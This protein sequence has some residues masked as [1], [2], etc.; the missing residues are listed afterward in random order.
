MRIRYGWALVATALCAGAVGAFA[1]P[2]LGSAPYIVY[3]F[4]P[5]GSYKG[6]GTV[7]APGAD[8]SRW[9]CRVGS[10]SCDLCGVCHTP[11]QTKDPTY[12]AKYDSDRHKKIHFPTMT[13][14][15]A[16]GQKL[17]WGTDASLVLRKTGIAVS[18]NT[19]GKDIAIMPANATILFN[20]LKQAQLIALPPATD[21]TLVP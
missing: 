13:A 3:V 1:S 11:T 8:G 17:A 12:V 10:D 4:N 9:A 16:P 21:L 20:R 2:A 18:L 6:R 5:D 7:D 19:S 15:L 14:T